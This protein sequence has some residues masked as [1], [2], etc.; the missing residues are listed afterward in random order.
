[1]LNEPIQLDASASSPIIKLFQLSSKVK[2][3][4]LSSSTSG[5]N[6]TYRMKLQHNNSATLIIKLVTKSYC[7]PTEYKHSSVEGFFCNEQG[8][9]FNIDGQSQLDMTFLRFYVPNFERIS[10]ANYAADNTF[11]TRAD[12][13]MAAVG[14][15][16]IAFLVITLLLCVST[17]FNIVNIIGAIIR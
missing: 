12:E 11:I 16:G 17:A 1:M 15:L 3:I 5:E 9:E 7:S 10:F 8:Y 4:D 2:M 6:T 14:L 13:E